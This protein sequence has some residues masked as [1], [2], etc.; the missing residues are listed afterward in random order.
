MTGL[1]VWYWRVLLGLPALL[2]IIQAALLMWVV[3]L[4]PP[5]M[6][7]HEGR[8][9]DARSLLYKIYGLAVPEPGAAELQNKKVA[10][11]E[12]Q[13]QE[14]IEASAE[15][16]AIPRIR[17]YQAIFDPFLRCPLLLGFG[18][19]A[20][21]Q[22]C[23]INAL[24]AYSNNLFSEAG[25]PAR[26]LTLASV[27]M[28]MANVG[29]SS[30]SSKVVDSWG[31]RNLLLT[32]SF[33]QAVCMAIITHLAP[34]LPESLRGVVTVICFN[35]FVLSFGAGLGAV[36]WLYLS[37]I[38]PME[39]RGPALSA[40]G[41]IKWLSCFVVVFGARFLSLRE[42]C[43]VFG[44]VSGIGWLGVWLWVVETR[45]CSL[46][47]SPLTPRSL[48]S[49]SALLTPNSPRSPRTDFRELIDEAPGATMT[50]VVEKH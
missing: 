9:G 21:Q 27:L 11:L 19:A 45:G 2:G 40:C 23:G 34:E 31:R 5:A 12:L 14:L 8:L 15:Q 13:L 7:I 30:V 43:Q 42:S 1:T 20:F 26:N 24:M 32:G 46:E 39:I 35:L 50:M 3:P 47:D 48:R 10:K 6:L 38:Y 33:L 4:D 44:I 37:E 17:I 49:S 25:I 36:T 22:L 16:K 41:V 28:S 29:V 18:L